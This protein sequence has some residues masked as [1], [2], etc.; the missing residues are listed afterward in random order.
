MCPHL[1][2]GSQAFLPLG[3]SNTERKERD[4]PVTLRQGVETGEGGEE[5][6][7]GGEGGPHDGTNYNALPDI[8]TTA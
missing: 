7:W 6:R 4:D 5:R 1:I 8:T 2:T 3:I